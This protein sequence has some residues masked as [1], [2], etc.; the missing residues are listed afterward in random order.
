MRGDTPGVGEFYQTLWIA[1]HSGKDAAEAMMLH[2]SA[3]GD[4]VLELEA[5]TAVDEPVPV[6]P[7]VSATG[8][9]Y[10]AGT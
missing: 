3:A 6:H 1:R 10:I 5:C 2:L 8:R 9:A 4:T 7:D